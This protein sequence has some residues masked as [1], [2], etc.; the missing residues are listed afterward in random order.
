MVR[1]L[2]EDLFF[3]LFLLTEPAF[4]FKGKIINVVEKL[5]NG[6][7][8]IPNYAHF[9]DVVE[10]TDLF[11]LAIYYDSNWLPGI[12]RILGDDLEKENILLL[13]HY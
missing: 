1:I 6:T 3:T 5:K 12:A 13:T 11:Y 7:L 8:K 10:K 2:G 4:E 9:I